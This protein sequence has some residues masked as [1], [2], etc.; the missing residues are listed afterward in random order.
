MDMKKFTDKYLHLI[1][2]SLLCI[3]LITLSL[4]SEGYY[5]GTDSLV[6]YFMSRYL[7]RHPNLFFDLWGRPLF[8]ILSS[9]FSQFGIHGIKIFNILTGLLAS[10]ISYLIAKKLK[11]SPSFLV[12]LL[13]CFT[14]LYC[15]TLMSALTEILFSLVLVLAV[16][17]FFE[18]KYI[19]SSVII[20]FLLF[21]RNEGFIFLPLFFL[22]FLAKKKVKAIPFLVTG[23]LFFSLIGS[24]YYKDLLWI[25]HNF[26][27]SVHNPA[28]YKSGS[29]FHF[30]ALHD[31]I[32]GAP[33]EI[34]AGI[35]VV[36][37]ISQFFSKDRKRR[38]GAF[39]EFLLI[40]GPFVVYVVFHSV[41]YWKGLGG[42]LGLERVIAG[43]LPLAAILGMKGY[44]RIN[45]FLPDA[46]MKTIILIVCIF[47]VT[48][49]NFLTYP[50]PIEFGYEENLQKQA[51]GW[52]EKSIYVKEQLYYTDFNSCFFLDTR[53][54][55]DPVKQSGLIQIH[56][57]NDL[58]SI[59]PGW[60]VQWDA[61]F[62]ANECRV[63]RDSVMLNPHLKLL[64]CFQDD[65]PWPTLGGKPYG[66]LFFIAL[67]HDRK[68]DN[69]SLIDSLRSEKEK[70]FQHK[71]LLSYDFET[72][73]NG[74]DS[75]KI[76][77]DRAYSGSQSFRIDKETGFGPVLEIKCSAISSLKKKIL[78]EPTA[79]VFLPDSLRSDPVLLVVSLEEKNNPYQYET[80]LL[81]NLNLK[82]NQWNRISFMV[83]LH[84]IKSGND[85]VKVYL[86]NRGKKEL[87]LDDF[88][89]E[90]LIPIASPVK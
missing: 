70:L 63:P 35:G 64:N 83:S 75:L 51:S 5:G 76:S 28:F 45:K 27:Y 22:A 55:I 90:A 8:T 10:Y 80:L 2:L 31:Q 62:G 9:P 68:A 12:I 44:H 39:Y 11:L 16:Y 38:S 30:F 89:V 49:M 23:F 40:P 20:S 54:D 32:M 85:V 88:K 4:F 7:L 71:I 14:P 86:W 73:S 53:P 65:N 59:P 82:L 67:P 21:A 60:I 47:L 87:F 41:L 43:V 79:F 61:H 15:I 13:V 50:Y 48:R 58:R 6:H 17:Y 81:N 57:V 1:I 3:L 34:L 74:I 24:F 36:Y 26:P 78:I 33:L 56:S 18:E 84:V 37:L 72:I 46:W 29:L 69:Y 77:R 19:L 42:S 66:I 25:I 52:F